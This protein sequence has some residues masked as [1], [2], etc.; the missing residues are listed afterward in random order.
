MNPGQFL[1]TDPP[2]RD[3]D[4]LVGSFTETVIPEFLIVKMENTTHIRNT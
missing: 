2:V 4:Y 3:G 1:K